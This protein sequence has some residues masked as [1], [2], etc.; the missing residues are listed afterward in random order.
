MDG[1]T[2]LHVAV[3]VSKKVLQPLLKHRLIDV[4]LK[5]RDGKWRKKKKKKNP[6][7]LFFFFFFSLQNKGNTAFHYFAV[8]CKDPNLSDSFE[9]FRVKGVD[10]NAQNNM[11]ETALHKSCMNTTAGR[12]L[13]QLLTRSGAAVNT[14]NVNGETAL[15]YAVRLLREDLVYLLLAAGADPNIRGRDGRTLLSIA[16]REAAQTRIADILARPD[17]YAQEFG[18]DTTAVVVREQ[19]CQACGSRPATTHSMLCDVCQQM[20]TLGTSSRDTMMQLR[21]QQKLTLL[22]LPLDIMVKILEFGSDRRLCALSQTCLKLRIVAANNESWYNLCLNNC[23]SRCARCFKWSH[24]VSPIDA[25][26]TGRQVPP[27]FGFYKNYYKEKF[28]RCIN[29][30][31]QPQAVRRTMHR[32]CIFCSGARRDPGVPPPRLPNEPAAG[33]PLAHPNYERAAGQAATPMGLRDNNG[34]AQFQTQTFRTPDNARPTPYDLEDAEAALDSIPVGASAGTMATMMPQQMTGTQQMSFATQQVSYGTG[35]GGGPVTMGTMQV[36]QQAYTTVQ[37]QQQPQQQPM[38]SLQSHASSG[39]GGV[40]PQAAPRRPTAG[41]T[42]GSGIV[43][44]NSGNGANNAAAGGAPPRVTGAALYGNNSASA[45]SS[46]ALHQQQP[47]APV[48]THSRNSSYA[49]AVDNSAYMPQ[50]YATQH[51]VAAAPA[52][53]P[54]AGSTLYNPPRAQQPTQPQQQQ[55]QP[56]QPLHASYNPQATHH[57]PYAAP[58]PA[59][60]TRATSQPSQMARP[61][62]SGNGGQFIAQVATLRQMGFSQT[63]DECVQALTTAHGNVDA[64]VGILLSQ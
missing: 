63:D 34:A 7:I 12:T 25:D 56:Q 52:P 54:A 42:A 22:T 49:P 51:R 10:L 24:S 43:I 11:G 21:A 62:A 20:T 30:S 2:L 46:P 15:H 57:D 9:L 1:F 50:P 5:N 39:V 18:G 45:I 38:P 37:P 28:E 31:D 61:T 60:Q 53:A 23:C 17:A 59:L 48:H 13:V 3:G 40:A 47:P 58:A 64:A 4:N 55:Q 19:L 36:P 16:Q 14:Q 33:E 35:M 41:S 8:N 26:A 27:L 6:L 29:M 32:R 44:V